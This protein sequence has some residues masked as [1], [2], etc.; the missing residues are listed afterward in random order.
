MSWEMCHFSA[1]PAK[2]FNLEKILIGS[3]LNHRI[4][5]GHIARGAPA[6]V[7]L[8]VRLFFFTVVPFQTTEKV[9]RSVEIRVLK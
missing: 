3:S 9:N 2:P 6:F 7:M 5:E 4:D 8:H 1:L